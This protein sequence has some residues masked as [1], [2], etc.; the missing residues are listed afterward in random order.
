MQSVKPAGRSAVVQPKSSQVQHEALQPVAAVPSAQADVSM[1]EDELCQAFSNSL[2]PVEDIDEGDSEMP[3]LCSEYVK[4]IYSYLRRLEV[5][6]AFF[7]A[8]HFG[9][10]PASYSFC[11]LIAGSAVCPSP[12][13]GRI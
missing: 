7:Y 8:A 2:F 1:K 10:A 5:H 12:L 11:A 3:Q 9:N 13:H 6:E 4:D